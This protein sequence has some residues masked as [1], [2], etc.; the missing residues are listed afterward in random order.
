MA[1]D[2]PYRMERV[3]RRKAMTWVY[4]VRKRTFTH[5]GKLE[6]TA[7]YAGAIGYKNDPQF[8]SLQ[9]KG[10]LPRGR[11]KIVGVPF[12]HRRAGRYTLRLS[13]YPSNNMFGRDGFLIH[14]DSIQHPGTASNGCI[15]L[16]PRFRHRIYESNDKE[17]IVK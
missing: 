4:D 2:T 14:G 9:D 7:R 10:P 6:F 11:Y 12:T 17:L 5:N 16:D 15:V 13:Q 8:E 1:R 3:S